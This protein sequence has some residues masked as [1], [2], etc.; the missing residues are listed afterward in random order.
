M[1]IDDYQNETNATAIYTNGLS[2]LTE[3]IRGG[4]SIAQWDYAEYGS[5]P[6]VDEAYE[7]L[8][9]LESYLTRVYPLMEMIG[10]VGEVAEHFK[11]VMR[12]DG[13]DFSSRTESIKK[14]MG[15]VSYG[16]AQLAERFGWN[17]SE[18]LQDNIYKL[19]DRLSRDAIKGDGDNR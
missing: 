14:E 3:K 11:K 7:A 19:R 5:N 18:I 1:K 2:E 10:E 9:K 4:L 6:T 13:F 16:W 15:D 8:A 17:C 12:D